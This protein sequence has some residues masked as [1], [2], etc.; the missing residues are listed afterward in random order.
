MPA[1][2]SEFHRRLLALVDGGRVRG[3]GSDTSDSIPARLSDGEFVLPADTVRKVGV[4]SLRDLVHMTHQPSG[5]PSH[6]ARFADGGP[7][8]SRLQGFNLDAWVNQMDEQRAA[9]T[10]AAQA[11][12]AQAL[13][14]ADANAARQARPPAPGS[15]PTSRAGTDPTSQAASAASATGGLQGVADRVSAMDSGAGAASA[16]LPQ[17]QGSSASLTQGQLQAAPTPPA[18][19]E[20]IASDRAA[21][22]RF[23]AGFVNG[24][25]N[26]ARAAGDIAGLPVRGVAGALDTAVVRPLRAAGLGVGYLSPH[27]VPTGVDPTSMT[28]FT[29]QKRQD[30]GEASAPFAASPAVPAATPAASSS[31]PALASAEEM[32][33]RMG[34][35]S[36]YSPA[37]T[38]QP[39][40]AVK[41]DWS[42]SGGTNAQ[43]AQ[44]NPQ[45]VVT[46]RRGAD[47]TMEFSGGNVSG[48]VSYADADGKALPG[49]GIDDKGFSAFS[50]APA[51]ANVAM[52]ANGSYAFAERGNAQQPSPGGQR[53]PV[54]MSVE[55]AQRE[56]LIGERVGYDPRFDQR[57]TVAGVQ[58]S[59]QNATS[60]QGGDARARLMSVGGGQLQ[61]PRVQAPTVLSSLNDWQRR[62]Q[63]RN[64][65]VS[66]NS[67]TNNGERFDRHKGMSPAMQAYLAALGAELKTQNQQPE[68]DTT[69]MRENADLQRTGMHEQGANQ[70]SLV[71]AALD[72]QRINQTGQTQRYAN[73]TAQ[74]IE[75]AQVALVGAKTP[76][77]QHDARTRLM[78]LMGKT[79]GEKWAHAPGGQVL[80]P[81]TQQLI[82]VPSTIYN[83]MTG[84]TKVY[85]GQVAGAEMPLSRE[86]LVK[87]QVYQ[88]ARGPGRWDGSNFQSVR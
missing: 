36:R 57:L 77:D 45:G 37:A 56:G 70:R 28:P 72:Q 10:R 88:T 75:D 48:P 17:E 4:R 63:L 49:G 74:R 51:G 12:G 55:Q 25:G 50:V 11:A 21:A 9:S 54:G 27:L 39:A 24:F 33:N 34:A 60:T 82:T 79:D 65:E 42:R 32:Q 19:A 83:Q 78:A 2:Q 3:P 81:K 66:A 46:A 47:G 87:G 23:G 41:Q 35:I 7:A 76:Q 13:A 59:V 52:G 58:P 18:D 84:E 31:A 38:G 73:R 20:Q 8:S 69:A 61:I 1:K 64:L 43:V 29:D 26:M 62:N 71:Q 30:G 14:E 15:E 68:M 85:G 5:K 40:A 80:D 86:K 53:S 16:T 44:A 22:G 67:I 6:P